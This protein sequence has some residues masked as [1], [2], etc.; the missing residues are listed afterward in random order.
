MLRI[1]VVWDNKHRL[2]PLWTLWHGQGVGVQEANI[3]NTKIHCKFFQNI[4]H[5]PDRREYSE[6]HGSNFTNNHLQVPG[7]QVTGDVQQAT[8]W[9]V[10]WGQ[11]TTWH[12]KDCV[13]FILQ[14]VGSWSSSTLHLW[15]LCKTTIW[16]DTGYDYTNQATNQSIKWPP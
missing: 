16:T 8:V 1:L 11:N 5:S 13:A 3:L 4:F 2:R 10:W 6:R 7:Y 14:I 12:L 9:D 15:I